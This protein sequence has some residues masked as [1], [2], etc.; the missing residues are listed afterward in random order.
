MKK[1]ILL[2]LFAITATGAFAQKGVNDTIIIKTKI[3][4]DHCKECSSCQPQIEQEL[5]FTKGVK[6]SKVNA[7]NQTITVIYNSDKTTPL[8]IKEAIS[9]SGYD[10]DDIKANPKAVAKLDECCKMPTEN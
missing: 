7:E 8:A 2:A 1:L 3:Y 9:N 6:L 4:C 10:A 5:R